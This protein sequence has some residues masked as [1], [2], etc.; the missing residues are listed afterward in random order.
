MEINAQKTDDPV[1]EKR[2]K[3]EKH[4]LRWG[5]KEFGPWDELDDEVIFSLDRRNWVIRGELHGKS[6]VVIDGCKYG[7]FDRRVSKPSYDPGRKEFVFTASREGEF[8][9]IANGKIIK[10]GKTVEKSDEK[11][12]LLVNSKRFG[13]YQYIFSPQFSLSGKR[14][15]ADAE[16]DGESWLLLDGKEYGPFK[17]V[18]C[19]E[20]SKG[21]ETCASRCDRGQGEE[22]LLDG[23][24]FFGPYA[25]MDGPIFSP[26][27]RRWGMD[28]R[29]GKKWY[30]FV[31]DGV[32]YGPFPFQF[33]FPRF[34]PDSSHWFVV[35]NG[36][37]EDKPYSFILD[38]KL[39]GRFKIREIGFMDEG[40]F[41]CTFYRRGRYFVN[42]DGNEIGPFGH[43]EDDVAMAGGKI[44][45]VMGFIKKG[46][47]APRRCVI[48][49]QIEESEKHIFFSPNSGETLEDA[50]EVI[51]ADDTDE[52]VAAE[53][54]Y[55]RL[56][57]N[58]QGLV[59]EFIQQ[60]LIPREG[61]HYDQLIYRIGKRKKFSLFFDIT[62]FYG[63]FTPEVEELIR[64]E[65]KE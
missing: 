37:Y 59:G 56:L 7:P 28:I 15:A 8:F 32:E 49:C 20:F 40:H 21:G 26:D 30:G 12:I 4:Y 14:W 41:L 34:S 58:S 23:E 5:S 1:I 42:L 11:V 45:A 6:Y 51:N 43:D 62:S 60:R 9:L 48:S 55:M 3:N 47:G 24:R 35:L 25:G 29:K 13:P 31:V 16:K 44:A 36:G 33:F 38:G 10:K 19:M 18:G 39:F 50:I 54:Q 53:H 52:G 22:L 65:N 2:G 17:R 64:G 63:K 61:K 46:K 57:L 27:G